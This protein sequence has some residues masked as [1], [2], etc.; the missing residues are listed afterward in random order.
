MIGI[1]IYG[2]LGDLP[3]G[4]QLVNGRTRVSNLHLLITKTVLAGSSRYL[5]YVLNIYGTFGFGFI[6]WLDSVIPV[7]RCGSFGS[8]GQ[9][10]YDCRWVA[11]LHLV[12]SWWI[13]LGQKHLSQSLSWPQN[14]DAFFYSLKEISF[15]TDLQDDHLKK[16]KVFFFFFWFDSNGKLSSAFWK[17]EWPLCLEINFLQHPEGS[18]Y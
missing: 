18:Y 10:S 14:L 1:A 9:P 13:Q 2:E 4:T 11:V 5:N 17:S 3:K 15:W 8:P 6:L 12:A 16:K 7:S